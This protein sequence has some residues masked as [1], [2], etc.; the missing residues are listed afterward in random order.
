MGALRAKDV[1]T[2]GAYPKHTYVE[3]EQAREKALKDALEV[4]GQVISLSGPSKSG[5]TV[6]IERVVGLDNL[7]TVGSSQIAR[8]DE[9]WERA[10]NW[11]GSPNETTTTTTL[12]EG[13]TG[14]VG[15][16]AEGNAVVV[17]GEVSGSYA[18][19]SGAQTAV[20]R[21]KTRHGMEQVAHEIA[22]SDF[23][24]LIDDFHYMPREVQLEVAKQIKEAVRLKIKIITAAVP[25]RADDV[26]RA[27]PE[28]RGRVLAIDLGYWRREELV[29]I[30]ELGFAKLGVLADQDTLKAFAIESA[31]SPQLMQAICL[32][33]CFFIDLREAQPDPKK[34]A[35][36]VTERVEVFERT[37][38]MTDFRSLVDVLDAGPRKRGAERKTYRFDD[39]TDGDVYRCVLKAIAAEPLR[40]SFD[41]NDLT[42]RVRKIC[43]GDAPVGSS[44]V[45]TCD[46]MSKLASSH[47]PRERVLD[48]DTTKSVLDI[49]DPYL[50]FFLR[51]SNR[52][53]EQD[54]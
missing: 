17:K 38:A 21:R 7:I 45:G 28:L 5:K 18:S 51:W 44:V 13:S 47:F 25:H 12:S 27:N 50:M 3:R 16:K 33:A 22:E 36:T 48:W 9:V 20:A 6:L 40:L 4:P 11:M 54:E 10:L 30:A 2:P 24:V 52:L 42:N 14:Q 34:F 1:F 31:G 37:A 41:Y 43:K 39:G 49:P 53:T 32:Q 8:A 35:L 46:H 23:A 19:T 29:K 15:T 26:V